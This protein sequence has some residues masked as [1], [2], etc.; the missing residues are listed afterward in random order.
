MRSSTAGFALLETLVASLLLTLIVSG[1]AVGF[2][3]GLLAW[4]RQAAAIDRGGSL[5]PTV[6]TLRSLLAR[7]TPGY[8]PLAPTVSGEADRLRVITELP[9]GAPVQPL[10]LADVFLAVDAEHRLTMRWTPHMHAKLLTPPV[11]RETV[12]LPGVA[13]IDFAY[14]AAD[15]GKWRTTWVGRDP[16]ALLRVHLVLQNP[17]VNWPDV[18]V[19]PM[20]RR[21]TD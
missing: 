6:R 16:P 4:E 17:Q 2:H 5:D 20:A 10:R 11:A 18:I 3:F 7:I 21:D 8:D 14:F 15:T 19:A 12:L 1:L 13:R 9:L